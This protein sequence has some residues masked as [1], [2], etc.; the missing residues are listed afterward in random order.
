MGHSG[1]KSAGAKPG[2]QTRVRS[3]TSVRKLARD[4]LGAR[5][6][7]CP[8]WRTNPRGAL[9]QDEPQRELSAES[10]R[11]GPQARSCPRP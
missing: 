8:V 5:E 6:D 9:A 10:E 1:L 3:Q 7:H 11:T 2:E 4:W